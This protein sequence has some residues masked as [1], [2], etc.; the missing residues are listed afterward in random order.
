MV[1]TGTGIR[2]TI[3]TATVAS[4][5]GQNVQSPPGAVY[6]YLDISPARYGT[7]TGAQI[8]FSIPQSWLDEHH[9]TPQDIV[10]YHNV[11]TGWQ[12]LPI[13][14]VKTQN[15]QVSLSATSPGFSRFAIAG[16]ASGSTGTQATAASAAVHADGVL[17]KSPAADSPVMPAPDHGKPVIVQTTAAPPAPAAPGSLA[18]ACSS[19]AGGSGGRTRRCSGSTISV[20]AGQTAEPR[21]SFFRRFLSWPCPGNA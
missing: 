19:G 5:P 12:A 11:G 18:A 20:M 6:L 21:S 17:V 4:G 13:T 3:I 16:K 14:V 8:T 15:G 7:I 9:L 1:V 2:D 10:L